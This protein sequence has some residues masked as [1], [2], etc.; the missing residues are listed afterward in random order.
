M[1]LFAIIEMKDVVFQQVRRPATLC[2]RT[3]SREGGTRQGRLDVEANR[4][5]G[6]A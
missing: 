3:V 4:H 5:Q 2:G 6:R 1:Y